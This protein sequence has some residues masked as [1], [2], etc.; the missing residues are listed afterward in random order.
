MK[1]KFTDSFVERVKSKSDILVIAISN[2]KRF[3][4]I[5]TLPNQCFH[6]NCIFHDDKHPSMILYRNTNTFRCKS[7]HCKKYGDIISFTMKLY[8]L[9]YVRAVALLAY[10]F[11][12][13]LKPETIKYVDIDLA[14]RIKLIKNSVLYIQLI[15]D[16]EQKTEKSKALKNSI[17]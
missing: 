10:V 9:D 1:L 4:N 15:I 7:T 3:N 11:N 6:T 14:K 2:S 12:I 5:R 13:G 17:N 16:S 8:N